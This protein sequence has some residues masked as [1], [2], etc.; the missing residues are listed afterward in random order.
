M[1]PRWLDDLERLEKAAT[2]G[3]WRSE[4]DEGDEWWFGYS[5][6]PGEIDIFPEDEA[7]E[8]KFPMGGEYPNEAVLIVTLR[9]RL[10]QILRALRAATEIVE[11]ETAPVVKRRRQRI[12]R[13]IRAFDA[14]MSDASTATLRAAPDATD[15]TEKG[16]A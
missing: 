11:A 7:S 1:T 12:R 9:N 4:H 3:P 5:N 13:A 15:T 10:P 6:G 2:P 16:K 8:F 14:A